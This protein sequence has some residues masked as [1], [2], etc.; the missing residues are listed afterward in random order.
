MFLADYFFRGDPNLDRAVTQRAWRHFL[1]AIR[2]S[3]P[4]VI[5][6]LQGKPLEK[7]RALV[8]AYRKISPE[9]FGAVTCIWD[10][11]PALTASNGYVFCYCDETAGYFNRSLTAFS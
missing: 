8:D 4:E 6:A 3:T 9:Q 2:D 10:G 5:Q 7:F 1:C 11:A